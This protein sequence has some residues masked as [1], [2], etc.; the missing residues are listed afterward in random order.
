[1]MTKL[2]LQRA[3]MQVSTVRSNAVNEDIILVLQTAL[4]GLEKLALERG[5]LINLINR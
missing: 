4:N 5:W 2:E 3:Y 1:M